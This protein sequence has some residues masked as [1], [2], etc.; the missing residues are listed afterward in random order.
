M[1]KDVISDT[2]KNSN[3]SGMSNVDCATLPTSLLYF[4]GYYNKES[5]EVELKWI[6]ASELDN[7]YFTLER[8]LDG[9]TFA[10]VSNVRGQGTT[11]GISKYHYTDYANEIKKNS[12]YYRLSQTDLDG[13]KKTLE[14]IYVQ[15]ESKPSK[16][17][18]YPT[19]VQQ[20]QNIYIDF[21][22]LLEGIYTVAILNTNG[23]R[24]IQE[25]VNINDN[26]QSIEIDTVAIPKG[27]YIIH[28]SSTEDT[29]IQRIIV[30]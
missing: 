25:H 10:A 28:I 22:G 5:G 3:D 26:F 7:N 18:I 1:Q 6:T 20:T 21:E 13:T 29:F 24:I 11:S 30:Q 16:V 14:E 8:S 15:R 17:W 12:C 23:D 9:L 2:N 19:P 27:L 4:I